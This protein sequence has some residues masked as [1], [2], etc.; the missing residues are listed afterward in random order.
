MRKLVRRILPQS[1]VV[2]YSLIWASEDCRPQTL[3]INL[4]VYVL[5]RVSRAV[6]QA[7]DILRSALH[8][9]RFASSDRYA[10]LRRNIVGNP[11]LRERAAPG[12]LNRT[13][14]LT[15]SGV[16]LVLGEIAA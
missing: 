5:R 1:V 11:I 8:C 14:N 7:D 4:T 13:L 6:A 12:V 16:K 9:V 15:C 10:N 3:G 2:P